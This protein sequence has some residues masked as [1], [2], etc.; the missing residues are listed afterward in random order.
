MYNLPKLNENIVE[1]S[2][3]GQCFTTGHFDELRRPAKQFLG[4]ILFHG[5]FTWSFEVIIA[6][7]KLLTMTARAFLALVI[8]CLHVHL[9][10]E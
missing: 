1:N 8:C 7:A 5:S 10:I 9:V 3:L 2:C 6:P 4:A